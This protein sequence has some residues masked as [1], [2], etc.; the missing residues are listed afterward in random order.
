MGLFGV[1]PVVVGTGI[2]GTA[3]TDER[4]VLGAGD[5]G[6]VGA[7]QI[8]IGVGSVREG[9]ESVRGDNLFYLGL[10]LLF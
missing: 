5:V 2:L 8:A 9:V 4:Q 10:V 3:G 7:A 6:G 1:H